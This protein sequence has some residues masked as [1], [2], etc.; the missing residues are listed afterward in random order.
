MRESL[1]PKLDRAGAAA[2]VERLVAGSDNR[3][4]G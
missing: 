1:S 2:T 4:S 3:T